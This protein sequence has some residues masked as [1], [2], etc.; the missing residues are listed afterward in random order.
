MRQRATNILLCLKKIMRLQRRCWCWRGVLTWSTGLLMVTTW[1][2]E[3]HSNIMEVA[4]WIASQY[5]G[6]EKSE[7]F[8]GYEA[9]FSTWF[10]MTEFS[11]SQ[12]EVVSVLND[13]METPQNQLP[14]TDSRRSP[15]P[16]S[17]CE[18]LC[19][20]FQDTIFALRYF[21]IS[22]LHCISEK[23]FPYLLSLILQIVGSFNN[24]K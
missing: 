19:Y 10:L 22:C 16:S 2:R 4:S 17:D 24:G 12:H 9:L 18:P 3:L 13:W 1:L 23:N 20:D 15:Y 11:P 6:L 7:E 8:A 5:C 14:T 21:P